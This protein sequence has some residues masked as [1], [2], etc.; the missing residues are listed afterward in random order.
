MRDVVGLIIAR[1]PVGHA[2]GGQGMLRA[3]QDKKLLRTMLS[4]KSLLLLLLLLLRNWTTLMMKTQAYV[5]AKGT[6]LLLLLLLRIQSLARLQSRCPGKFSQVV[7][8]PEGTPNPSL[9]VVE[10]LENRLAE[11]RRQLDA[12]LL[13]DGD[14]RKVH[15]RAYIEASTSAVKSKNSYVCIY[16]FT[17]TVIKIV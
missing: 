7:E 15:Q 9:K 17:L 12:Q 8:I 10:C 3:Q 6:V 14:R 5:T 2:V 4:R 1:A 16:I 11:T 13:I